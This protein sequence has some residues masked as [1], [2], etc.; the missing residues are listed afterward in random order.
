MVTKV[1]TTKKKKGLTAKQEAERERLERQLEVNRDRLGR[2]VSV[3]G[4]ALSEKQLDALREII[5]VQQEK[6]DEILALL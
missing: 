3:T 1:K 4:A 2:S 6:L 5:R